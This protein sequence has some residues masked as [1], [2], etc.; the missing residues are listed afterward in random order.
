MQ[1]AQLL[2]REWFVLFL[3]LLFLFFFLCVASPW[4]LS[5]FEKAQVVQSEISRIRVEVFGEV[6]R[7]GMYEVE[8]GT[9][10]RELV[11]KAGLLRS[12]DVKAIYGKK[13]LLRS[14]VVVVDSKERQKKE[15]KKRAIR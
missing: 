9:S 15:G 2:Y 1:Q 8:V 7:P 4:S 6:E 12:S 14:C 10:I 3:A 5:C 11:K 13:T